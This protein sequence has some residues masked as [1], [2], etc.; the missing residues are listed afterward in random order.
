MGSTTTSGQLIPAEIHAAPNRQ[1]QNDEAM[2]MER[3][4]TLSWQ[5]A[6]KKLCCIW[7]GV[8]PRWNPVAPGGKSWLAT[9][10]NYARSTFLSDIITVPAFT[11]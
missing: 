1:R 4:N 10:Q 7:S 11:Q 9:M 2:L 5:P 8:N 3:D 6:L